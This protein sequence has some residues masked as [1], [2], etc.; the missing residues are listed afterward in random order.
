[1]LL[2]VFTV[3]IYGAFIAIDGLILNN[4]ITADW[5]TPADLD[6]Y[7]ER[8]QAIIEGKLLYTD[9]H[10][11]TPP[12]INYILVPAQLLG[13]GEHVY[14]AYFSFF[15]FL[16]ATA[17]YLGLRKWDEM[18]AFAAAMLFIT[19]PFAVAEATMGVED[20]PIIAFIFILP[21]LLLI[22]ERRRTSAFSLGLGVW[23]KMFTLLLYPV[24]LLKTKET[25]E[26]LF[27]IVII[28][29]ITAVITIPFIVLCGADFTWFLEFYFLG[30]ESR[31]T[32]GISTW[33]FLH[34]GG[35]SIPSVVMV[36]ATGVGI[37]AGLWYSVKRELSTWKMATLITLIF[38]L[39]YPKIHMGYYLMPLTLLFI[40]G[41]KDFN[42]SLRCAVLF[43]PLIIAVGFAKNS[44]GVPLFDYSWG[45]IAGFLASLAG[46]LLLLDTTLRALR[47]EPFVDETDEQSESV[48]Q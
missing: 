32:G 39:L 29:G 1:M 45:W 19:S 34:M 26:R 48:Q 9:V 21:L 18:G 20:E 14:A 31:G 3:I 28:L 15:C 41:A 40:W 23:T 13:G 2:L 16:T 22:N 27:H 36:A 25:E 47:R 5:W 12:L 44:P 33:A 37:L 10:T 35:I 46:S 6:V 17:L 24:L 7:R 38:F 11:E 42:I 8:T 4:V 43:I 30:V